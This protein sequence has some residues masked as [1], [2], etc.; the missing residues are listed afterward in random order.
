MSLHDAARE[1]GVEHLPRP[2]ALEYL[3][4]ARKEIEAHGGPESLPFTEDELR[5]LD[6]LILDLDR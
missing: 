6:A 2:D 3:R 1:W 4:Q 5:G